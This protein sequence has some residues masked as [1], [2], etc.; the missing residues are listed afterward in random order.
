GFVRA[1]VRSGDEDVDI[2]GVVYLTGSAPRPVRRAMLGLWFV[3]IAVAS[4]SVF[5][6]RPP[7]GVMAP[8]WGIGLITLWASRHGTFPRRP[9]GT[10]PG[11]RSAP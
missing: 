8:V 4:A 1:A 11:R 9:P 3:Q 5:T 10:G 2:A 7:F 6:V